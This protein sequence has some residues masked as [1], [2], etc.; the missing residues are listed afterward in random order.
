MILKSLGAP[1]SI[2]EHVSMKSKK[3]KINDCA[4]TWDRFKVLNDSTGS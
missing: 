4:Y 1:L 2:W 3:F